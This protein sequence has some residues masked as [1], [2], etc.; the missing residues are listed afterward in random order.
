MLT[1]AFITIA[2]ATLSHGLPISEN[3]KEALEGRQFTIGDGST[4]FPV[5]FPP[6]TI[7]DV[8]IILPPIT[9]GIDPDKRGDIFILPPGA[10]SGGIIPDKP[11]TPKP[12]KRDDIF[13][14]PG[15]VT[16]GLI[17]DKPVPGGPLVPDPYV[18]GGSVEPSE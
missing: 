11:V 15:A 18:P 4:T 12:G 13:F 8:P 14:P 17:P 2:L 6:G 9:G 7:P 10:I 5:P 16:G 3:N 1:T